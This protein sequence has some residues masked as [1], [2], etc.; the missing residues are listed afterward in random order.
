MSAAIATQLHARTARRTRSG[1]SLPRAH[2]ANAR[3][4]RPIVA[5]AQNAAYRWIAETSETSGS[6][7]GS[8]GNKATRPRN[9]AQTRSIGLSQRGAATR[10]ATAANAHAPSPKRTSATGRSQPSGV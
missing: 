2:F 4:M 1:H 3:P 9:P 7:G 6:P 8:V 5:N 10:R